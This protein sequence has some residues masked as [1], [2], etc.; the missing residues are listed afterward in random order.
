MTP[1][2]NDFKWCE[3]I[4]K[5]NSRSF[6]RAFSSLPKH[7]ADCIY[8]IYAFCRIADD[9][10]DERKNFNEL[11]VLQNQ[12]EFFLNG[13]DHDTPLWRSLRYV[14]DNYDMDPW[15]FRAMI[16][17]QKMDYDFRQPESQSD[18]E[19]YCYCVAGSVGL[20]ITPILSDKHNEMRKEAVNLGIAMQLT[21]I[22][23]DIGE[24]YMKGRIYL[25]EDKMKEFG[26]TEEDLRH[27]TLNDNFIDL[28]EDQAKRAEELYSSFE[29]AF[30]YLDD[31]SL[32]PVIAA[33]NLYSEIL[34]E[35]RREGYSSLQ[36]RAVVS[37]I[38]KIKIINKIKVDIKD[39]SLTEENAW[40]PI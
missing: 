8:A 29:N 15:A 38:E 6:Y 26:Y 16:S 12:L 31:D 5:D 28:W 10:I 30:G 19:S 18:L 11:I 37:D 22:L 3:N 20:M 35:I 40:I 7:K 21:N 9:S 34:N 1:T 33:T 36:K 27:K 13:Y 32:F 25:P 24:D 17:G 2:E 4:I 23:R 39:M 14:F